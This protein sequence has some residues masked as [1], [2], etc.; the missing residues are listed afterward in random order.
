MGCEQ[1]HQLVDVL[2]GYG[3]VEGSLNLADLVEVDP[4]AFASLDAALEAPQPE[5]AMTSVPSA[6]PIHSVRIFSGLPLNS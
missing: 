2:L 6:H 3:L 4:A 1:A 5:S